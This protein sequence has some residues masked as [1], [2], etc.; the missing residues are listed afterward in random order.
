MR[1]DIL[2]DG[3][4]ERAIEFPCRRTAF[5]FCPLIQ[6]VDA[7]G[8]GKANVDYGAQDSTERLELAKI[9]YGGLVGS[10]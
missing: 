7:T 5:A 6:I 8:Y 10:H 4:S 1:F 3:P 2:H 9:M